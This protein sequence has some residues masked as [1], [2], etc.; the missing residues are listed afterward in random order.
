MAE[1]KESEAKE[2]EAA[3]KAS[4]AE[5]PGVDLRRLDYFIKNKAKT[6]IGREQVIRH[7]DPSLRVLAGTNTDSLTAICE[8]GHIHNYKFYDVIY[9]INAAKCPSCDCGNTFANEIHKMAEEILGVVFRFVLR[10]DEKVV[11]FIC[12]DLCIC[13]LAVDSKGAMVEIM[14][15]NEWFYVIA[16]R[17]DSIGRPYDVRAMLANALITRHTIASAENNSEKRKQE[18]LENFVSFVKQT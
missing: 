18:L 2:L 12:K 5:D 1:T 4:E 10:R 15:K 17:Y 6:R 11:V 14:R 7:L 16:T 9:T 13:L 8:A 3:K